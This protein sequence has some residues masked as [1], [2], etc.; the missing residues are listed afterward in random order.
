[1]CI[2]SFISKTP[3]TTGYKGIVLENWGGYRFMKA[4]LFQHC[5]VCG[6]RKTKLCQV[7]IRD[8]QDSF[9]LWD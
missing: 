8:S 9:R 4:E 5:F 3:V 2:L 6:K 1:M 7:L